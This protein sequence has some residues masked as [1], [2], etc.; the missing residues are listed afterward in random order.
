MIKIFLV[1]DEVLIRNGI[2]NSIN[3]EKEGYVFAGEA[4]D[5]ELA[6]PLILKEKPD[7]LLTD[8]KMPFMDG[9]ELSEAVKKELPDIKIIVLSGYNDFDFAQRGIKIGITNYLLKP[10]SAEKLLQA[11]G[12]VAEK[13]RREREERELLRKYE[14]DLQGNIVYKKQKYLTRIL[15]ENLSVPEI[16]DA[17]H[18]L[19]MELGA[20]VYNFILF[21]F[22]NY[23]SP[24]LQQQFVSAYMGVKACMER[25]GNI[26]CFQRDDKGWAFLLLA[27]DKEKLEALTET[28]R[29]ELRK[30]LE[31]FP[32]T[33]YFG[34]IG[35]SVARLRDLR[36]SFREAERAFACRF[37]AAPNQIITWEELH[38]RGGDDPEVHGLGS[39][40]ENRKL[41]GKFLR[42]G[43]AE[44]A[45][46]FAETYFAEILGEN[47]GSMMMR[48][49]VMMD[50]YIS[51]ASFGQEIG[52]SEEDIRQECGDIKD[53]VSHIHSREDMLV[54]VR[55]LIG[56]MLGLR[57]RASGDRYGDVIQAAKSYMNENYM[58]EEISLGSVAASVGMSASYFSSIFS[59]ETG[60][61]FVEYLTDIRME[62]AKELLMCSSKKTSEIGFDVGYKD[63]HYFSSIFKKTQG[64]SPKEYRSRKG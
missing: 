56:G 33:E 54:F 34:G 52:I 28:C 46:S 25:I 48:Q 22:I 23:G 36:V 20:G 49:Y 7:I 59:Q 15:T 5:G 40:Q 26:Y 44:E 42:N 50:I 31:P 39:M 37:V 51:I 41:I 62:K 17:G 24:Q 16:L 2:K 10:I 29:E 45:E 61:T 38:G 19:G 32:E 18:E 64:C 9:L 63:S 58:S 35:K 14:E 60:R 3:W 30:A 11:I 57:D 27:D 13:I 6:Y 21:K 43:T 12:E 47:I 1:E 4:G 55:R 8:I 53:I